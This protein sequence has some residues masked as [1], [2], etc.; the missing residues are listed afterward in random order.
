[1]S[2]FW[3]LT[4][5][6]NLKDKLQGFVVVTSKTELSHS[7]IV[8][9]MDGSVTLQLSAKS[10]G[11]FEAFYNSLKPVQLL[12]CTITVAS[13]GK[14][15]A[16]TT[17]LPFEIPLDPKDSL[18][19]Y[20]TYHGVFVNIQ[21]SLKVD[22]AR[23]LLAKNLS[24]ALEFIIETEVCFVFPYLFFLHFFSLNKIQ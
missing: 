11:L 9:T 21:Y 6:L 10:V 3:S 17:E 16:G 8:L 20:E 19:L 12:Q 7:G 24:K 1:V 5:K 15:P 23:P 13:A 14:L 18:K 22:M 2:F 4:Q